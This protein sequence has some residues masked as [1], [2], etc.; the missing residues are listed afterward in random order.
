MTLEAGLTLGAIVV[1][2]VVLAFELLS[3][4]LTLMGALAFLIV[5]RVVELEPALAGF[6]NPTLLAL[7]SLFVIAEGL[8]QAGV[9]R[10]AA[11]ALV[12]GTRHLRAILIRLTT[13]SAVA[14]AFLNNTPIVAMGIPTVISSAE[15]RKDVTPSKLLIPLSYASIFG[16]LCTLIGT[17][18]NL[19]ADGLLRSYGYPG[20]GFF[21]MAW[22][23]VPLAVVGIGL[24][25]TVVP[26]F[27][28]R[29]ESLHEQRRREGVIRWSRGEAD[30]LYQ[31]P[32][33]SAVIGRT[34]GDVGLDSGELEVVRI[35]RESGLVAPVGE[36][37]TIR[38]GDYL[39]FRGPDE[40]M[41]ETARRSGLDPVENLRHLELKG[42]FQLRE[43]VI[44]EGSPLASERVSSANFPDRYGAVVTA[45][46]R[47]GRPVGE[48][49][50]RVVLRPGDTL[51]LEAT[52]GFGRAYAA[53]RDFYLVGEEPG[54][55]LESAPLWRPTRGKWGMLILLGVIGLAVA[56]VVH[57]SVAALSGA[58]VM[59]CTGFLSPGDVHRSIDWSVLVV[60]G[61]ALGLAAAMQTSGA[62]E[63]VARGLVHLGA[64]LGSY[65]VLAATLLACSILSALITNN[66]AVALLFP[67]AISTAAAQ[68]LDP[69]PFV[70]G[71]TA[72]ASLSFVT[73]IGYQTNLMVYGPG[74]YRFTD[75]V[76]VG[77]PL[78]VLAIGV[79]VFL[80]PIFWPM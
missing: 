49:P 23:G 13:T 12:G 32:A 40:E 31:V 26:R 3:A 79:A 1:A 51:L 72:A 46:I 57:I 45:V 15:S 39:T 75:F 24:L 21:E 6:A 20:L 62:A 73:P 2:L 44:P 67:M 48:D 4:D 64:P 74:G 70:I 42:P 17:S 66:A 5:A 52:E 38:E 37:E 58:L 47:H 61:A 10:K 76:K 36:D 16:G 80:I 11:D 71:V 41:D 25:V 50:R 33:Q 43:A 30:H 19:V 55:E 7:G 63:L 68:G 27:L 59:V 69:R 54:E 56:E 60:I 9:L 35:T 77:G 8:R 34:V 22:L 78:Q 65:G 18:T 14:S 53:T 28:P 29:R